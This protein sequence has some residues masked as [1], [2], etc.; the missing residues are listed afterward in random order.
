MFALTS[1]ISIGKFS[2][3]KPNNVKISKSMYEFVDRAVLKMPITARIKRSGEVITESV[4]TAKQFSEGDKVVIKLGYNS[5][6]KSEF[7]GFISRVNFTA[8]L[9]VECEGYSYLLRKKSYLKTFVNV[10]LIDVLKYLISGTD[11]ILDKN[12]PAFKIDKI[13]FQNATGTEALE[14]IKKISDNTIR[15]FFTANVLY[16]SLLFLKPKADVKFRMRWNVIKD[17]NLKLRQAK[18]QVLQ[19]HYVGEKKDGSKVIRKA[20]RITAGDTKVIK[21]HAITDEATLSGMADAKLKSLSFDGYE[22]KI[23]AFGIPYCEPGDR[24]ILEDTKYQERSGNYLVETTEVNYGMSG[25]R[26]IIGIGMK[27]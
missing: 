4:E 2:G 1:D 8:P 17:G 19:V 23:T 20:G 22:G 16:A 26:R 10:Q 11:I 5:S 13:I 25:F 27:L 7:E 3:V 21:S 18:D 6:L 15:I 14:L 12:I 9:E 24:V